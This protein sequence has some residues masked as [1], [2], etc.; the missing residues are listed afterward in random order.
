MRV[1][2]W[3]TPEDSI[4]WPRVLLV[5]VA[6]VVVLGVGTAAAISLEP[7]NPYNPTWEGTS[8]FRSDVIH[9]GEHDGE[10]MYRFGYDDLDGEGTVAFV[11]APTD[12][13]DAADVEAISSFLDRGGTLIVLDNF[14]EHGP[15]LLDDLGADARLDGQVLRDDRY[16][17]VG[18]AMPV[19]NQ[20]SPHDLTVGVETLALNFG[21][22]IRVDSAEVLIATSEFAYLGPELEELDDEDLRSYA[23]ATVEPMGDGQ[24]VVVGD[25]SITINEMLDRGDN[26]VFLEALVAD[27]E[28]VVMDVSRAGGVPPLWFGLLELRGSAWLQLGLG[29]L[30]VLTIVAVAYRG[31]LRTRFARDAV[32]PPTMDREAVETYLRVYHHDL[33]EAHLERVMRA[34][35]EDGGEAVSDSDE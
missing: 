14:G 25:P 32:Q 21:T 9:G 31:E 24:L 27:A 26:R 29:V 13:Y 12:G 22:A 7:F 2:E 1:F 28:H 8:E 34:L 18:P 33:D 35:N 4:S 16:Y 17:D 11:V 20:I 15:A 23:V 6:V 19:A 10:V 3:F 30:A 5:V